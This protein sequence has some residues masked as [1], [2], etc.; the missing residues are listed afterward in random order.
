MKLNMHKLWL[1]VCLFTLALA[2]NACGR[3]DGISDESSG[4]VSDIPGEVPARY[5][6]LSNPLAGDPA[7]LARGKDAFQAL[8]S[9][10][11]GA[12]G[13][14]DG[15]EAVGFTPGPGDLTRREMVSRSDG[16]LFW[17]IAEGGSFEPFNSLMPAWGSL[18]GDTEIWELVS[19][20]RDFSQ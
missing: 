2:L 20:L 15:P 18:L 10:C 5:R 7:A 11:H 17:R 6:D 3:G 8:C 9:Q 4:E 13:R 16:Y 19:L 14:G 12:D 1:I